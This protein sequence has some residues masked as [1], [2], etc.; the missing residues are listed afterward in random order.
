M[1]IYS[2]RYCFHST[3]IKAM[4]ALNVGKSETPRVSN[5]HSL[6]EAFKNNNLGDSQVTTHYIG[7]WAA[8]PYNRASCP[9][10]QKKL[11]CG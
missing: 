3:L 7:A 8:R 10:P 6:A 1:R 11:A 2:A 5:I 9:Y 4:P